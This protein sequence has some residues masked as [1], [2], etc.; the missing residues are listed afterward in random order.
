[1]QLQPHLVVAEPFAGHAR[2]L[3]ERCWLAK[4]VYALKDREG[5]VAEAIS[6]NLEL[7]DWQLLW[8]EDLKRK[9][10]EEVAR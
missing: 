4:R 7:A 10:I 1:M 6:K 5:R 9:L 3:T 2:P 8:R